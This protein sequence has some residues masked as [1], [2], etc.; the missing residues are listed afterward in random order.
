MVSWPFYYPKTSSGLR[1]VKRV[2]VERSNVKVVV[3]KAVENV[4]S[5]KRFSEQW[6][7]W[8][9]SA[10]V[11]RFFGISTASGE[12]YDEASIDQSRPG[13]GG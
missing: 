7:R 1:F 5:A 9:T 2:R 12:T 4:E 3:I 8:K 6:E 13:L 11:F 10:L